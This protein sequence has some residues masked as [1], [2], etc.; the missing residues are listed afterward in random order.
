M[1]ALS[2]LAQFHEFLAEKLSNGGSP[3][4]PEEALDE[5]RAAHPSAELLADDYEAVEQALA[6]MEAGD[7]G[8]PFEEFDRRFRAKHKLPARE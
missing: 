2:E 5:W 1:D 4:S 8:T 3:L 7:T 6:D